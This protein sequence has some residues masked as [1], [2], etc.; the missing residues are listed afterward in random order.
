MTSRFSLSN[1][2]RNNDAQRLGARASCIS[3]FAV[4]AKAFAVPAAVCGPLRHKLVMPRRIV[5][6]VQTGG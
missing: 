5:K 6:R 1:G 4:G 3:S 2:D